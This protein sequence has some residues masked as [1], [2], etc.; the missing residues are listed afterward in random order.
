MGGGVWWRGW[1]LGAGC[2]PRIEVIVEMP[3][4]KAGRGVGGGG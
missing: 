1:G 4:K 2:E 3:K